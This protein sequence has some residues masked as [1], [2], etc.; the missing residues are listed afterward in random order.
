[1]NK[2]KLKS[3]L[4]PSGD[5][6]N[7][8]KY[9]KSGILSGKKYQTMLGVTGAGKTFVM[10]N[11]I[12]ETNRP[13]LVISHNKT[14]AAQLY[15]EF[16]ELF[17]EN[18]VHYFVS[19]YDY[20]QPE[21]YIPHSDTYIEKDA[22]INEFIDRM[23]HATTQDMLSRKDFIIVASVS[24]IYG[25]GNPDEYSNAS[26]NINNGMKI[27]RQ[28]LLKNL[29]ELQ[30]ERNDYES[31]PGTYSAK[32]DVINII[33]SDGEKTT[34]IE[35]LGDVIE[36]I[37]G[38]KKIF[39]AKHFVTPEDKLK[40]AIQ[41]IKI[42]LADR[43]KVLKKQ[44][45]VL[46]VERLKQ[47]T[48]F[49]I[50]ML[51]TTGYVTGIENYSRH[52]SFKAVGEPP[53][54]LM[55]YLPDNALIFI[56]ESHM[57]IPQIRGMYNGD[58]ARKTTLVD[59]G[60]RLPS[61]L[62]NRPLKFQEFEKKI[63]QVIFVSA[64]PGPY[65]LAKSKNNIVEQLIR[66]TGLLDP[67]IEVHPASAKATEGRSA[68]NQI[69]D[70]IKEIK[71]AI[72]KKERILVTTITKRSSEDV[73]EH[74][75]D[76]NIRAE[77]LHSEI[78]ALERPEILKKLREGKFDVLVG[79]NLL[80]EGLD[81][82]EV[83]LVAILDADKEGFLRNET[84]LIQT[85]GRAAR[86]IN[87]RAILYADKIT[88]SMK[89]AISETNRRRKLQEEYNKK[90]KISPYQIKKEIRPTF[91]RDIKKA[92]KD[93]LRD[94]AK[95]FANKEDFTRE[96]ERQMLEAADSLDFEKAAELRDILKNI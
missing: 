40:I 24:C 73:A 19:Y 91:L 56:D 67:K 95:E 37:D 5:Q 52:F 21:A 43:L 84:T 25:I 27:K 26:L 44:G 13:T 90:H 86:H 14:L 58:R 65:E 30:Y 85:I 92:K 15:Q 47:K 23:R 60:F 74:L 22:K 75:R 59:Y 39:P 4:K 89:R 9:L 88:D 1:M 49:D 31:K 32:G 12:A 76:N 42:E 7:A 71:K 50:E 18:S 53:S 16:K 77:Y 10:S 68:S 36:N 63:N 87:G 3:N 51:E 20:Y 83:A 34:K 45:K 2:F 93:K 64:T 41:N 38:E 72:L 82:P 57:S 61:A 79:V 54:T 33:F 6:P 29:A 17:P 28:E 70:L 66:P 80:R 8:I 96:L 11:I 94:L 35:M 78:K 55:D 48:N 46:E 62:D 69:E 81:L